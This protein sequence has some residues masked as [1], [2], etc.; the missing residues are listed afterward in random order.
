MLLPAGVADPHEDFLQRYLTDGRGHPAGPGRQLTGLRKDGSEVPIEL[1]V[2]DWKAGG[3]Q[4]FT[5]VIR[6]VSEQRELQRQLLQSQKLDALGQ[7]AGGVAHDFNNLL[8]V[9]VGNLDML[10]ALLDK[11]PALLKRVNTALAA[12]ER[13]ASLTKRLLSFARSTPA[14]AERMQVVDLNQAVL[15][16]ADLLRQPVD[17]GIELQLDLAREALPVRLDAAELQN[18]LLNLVFNARDAMPQ[19]GRLLVATRASHEREARPDL[20]AG[21]YVEVSVSD[22]GSGI[23]ESVR[24]RIFDPFFTTKPKGKGTGLGLPLVYS[25]LK[26]MQGAVRLESTVGA[27]ST[28]RLVF[29][30]AKGQVDPV[31]IRPAAHSGAGQLI[32]VVDDERA[33]LDTVAD[34]LESLGYTTLRFDDPVAAAVEIERRDDLAMLFTDILMPRMTGTE[35]ATLAR[36]RHPGL[37]VLLYTGYPDRYLDDVLLRQPGVVL[38]SKPVARGRL[39]GALQQLLPAAGTA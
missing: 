35:L 4:F 7:L 20:P 14:Q 30:R 11:Q 18:A 37:P 24:E 16:I 9:V 10:A 34:Q 2:S 36:R 29:P 23:P 27:G 13:G 21:D 15:D 39:V 8:G 25:Y 38:L 17:S 1:A 31:Q 6:D 19:G 26:R 33:L 32:L 22:T 3:E 5:G 12:A 28:F